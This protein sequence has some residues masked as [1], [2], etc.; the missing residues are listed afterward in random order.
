MSGHKI[1]NSHIRLHMSG[2]NEIK[3]FIKSFDEIKNPT[4]AE[5][6]GMLTEIC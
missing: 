5:L 6:R 4:A 1:G 2:I 3:K